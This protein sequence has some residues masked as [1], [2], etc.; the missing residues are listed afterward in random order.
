VV[1][2][3]VQDKETLDRL[4]ELGCDAAQGEY[5]SPPLD[6]ASV[7]PWLRQRESQQVAHP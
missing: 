5:L 1:A 3:G 6:G 7:L 4:R 2:E